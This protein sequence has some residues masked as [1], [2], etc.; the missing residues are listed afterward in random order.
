VAERDLAATSMAGG[1]RRVSAQWSTE[2]TRGR[3]VLW[4]GGT[5]IQVIVVITVLLMARHAGP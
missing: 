3:R 4:V 1:G 2:F 5:L